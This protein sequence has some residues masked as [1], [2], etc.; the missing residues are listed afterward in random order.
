MVAEERPHDMGL[1]GLVAPL[2]HR[3]QRARRDLVALA[4]RQRRE[5][6]R[7]RAF[8]IARHQEAARR[9]GRERVDVLARLAQ[10]GG[11]QLGDVA[12]AVLVGL[13]VRVEAGERGAPVGR[14]RRAG[15]GLARGDRLARPRRV[16]LVE[17]RQVEQPFAGIVDDV[18]VEARRCRR[19]SAPRART[20]SSG[21]AARCAGSTAAS[22]GRGRRGS[23]DAPR[24]RSAARRR[25]AAARAG[26]GRCVPRPRRRAPAAAT[27]AIEIVDQRG[28]EH[29]LAGAR[30]AGDAEPQPAAGEIV[31]ERAR[32][33]ARLEG[34]IGEK[35]QGGSARE[36]E[37]RLFRARVPV[38]TGSVRL[39]LESRR[40]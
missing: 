22:G 16:G 30:Q 13:G 14:E 6:Q 40:G 39:G 20:R 3:R 31:A 12:R 4:E 15:A 29:R 38:L 26:R 7:R 5:G 1:I 19:S 8:E 11:E 23:P 21:E 36:I 28:D 35:R 24:R 18:E 32:D 25:R 2:H 37:P 17:Q 34:E 10:I 27:P 33:D 9:Q